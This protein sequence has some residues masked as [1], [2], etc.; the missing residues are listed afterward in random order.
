MNQ[1]HS[2]CHKHFEPFVFVVEVTKDN[3]AISP[4]VFP[5]TCHII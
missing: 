3:L 4:E 5:D 2:V 1:L